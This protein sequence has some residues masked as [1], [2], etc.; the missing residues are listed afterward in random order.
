MALG[1]VFDFDAPP[2]NDGIEP[3]ESSGQEGQKQQEGYYFEISL[4]NALIFAAALVLTLIIAAAICM[5]KKK[6]RGAAMKDSQVCEDT[7]DEIGDPNSQ[8]IRG[9]QVKFVTNFKTADETTD[10]SSSN[11]LPSSV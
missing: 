10:E 4:T 11:L 9:E 7:A 1:P 6:S 3:D 2:A 8:L 5:C